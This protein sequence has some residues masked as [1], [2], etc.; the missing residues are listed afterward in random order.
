MQCGVISLDLTGPENSTRF[1]RLEDLETIIKGSLGALYFFK[2][3]TH[4][5]MHFLL[6]LNKPASIQSIYSIAKGQYRISNT[7]K[8]NT[9]KTQLLSEKANRF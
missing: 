8:T 7:G 1:Q 2:T 9:K 4:Y 3:S 5:M 6:A